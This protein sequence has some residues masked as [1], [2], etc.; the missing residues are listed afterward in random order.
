MSPLSNTRDKPGNYDIAGGQF[1]NWRQTL[2]DNFNDPNCGCKYSESGGDDV[3]TCT[4]A[5]AG[6]GARYLV[7][8]NVGG[9][10]SNAIELRDYRPP[11]LTR[12]ALEGS[13]L[14]SRGGEEFKLMGSGF[15]IDNFWWSGTNKKRAGGLVEY[16]NTNYL[17]SR[18]ILAD[19]CVIDGD[20]LKCRTSAGAGTNLTFRVVIG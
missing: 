7:T 13:K 8:M 4:N 19:Q 12:V 18:T 5:P 2:C 16:K 15:G 1:I 17:H 11:V 20:D 3:I 14:N 6:V 10:V 9:Q